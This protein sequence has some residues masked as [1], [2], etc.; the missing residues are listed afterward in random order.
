MD[1]NKDLLI[2]LDIGTD[3]IGWATTDENFDLVRIKGKTA[4]GSR[5]FKEA[6]DAKKRRLKRTNKRRL[7]RRNYRLKLLE[8]LFCQ[9]NL[10]IDKDPNFFNRMNESILKTE[11]KKYNPYLFASLDKEKEFYKHFPTIWHLR[12]DLINND[13]YALSDIRFVYLAI[14]HIIKYRGN[15]LKEGDYKID[16]LNDDVFYQVNEYIKNLICEL[17]DE[18]YDDVDYEVFNKASIASIKNILS[19]NEL[20]KITKKKEI[21]KLVPSIDNKTVLEHITMFASLICGSSYDISK[22]DKE[23]YEKKSIQFNSEFDSEEANLKMI[24]ADKYLLV[25]LAKQ[26][27][28]YFELKELLKDQ[29]NISSSFAQ[30]FETHKQCLKELKSLCRMVDEKYCLTGSKSVYFKI[31]KDK[32]S[33]K[34]YAAFVRVNSNAKTRNKDI[35]ILDTF[36]LETL[37][38]Y[39]EYLSSESQKYCL[40]KESC[41]LDEF[42]PIIAN[43]ST[44][45]IPHQLHKD[46]LIQ[47]LNNASRVY[48]KID[49]E[50]IDK[51]VKLFMFRVPYYYG[52]LSTK[53]PYS[54]V[55]RNN[56][57]I[58]TPWNI[59]EVIDDTKTKE[60]FMK[61]LTNSCQYL[62]GENVLPKKSIIYQQFIILDRLNAL[63]ING[64][65]ISQELKEDIYKNIILNNSKTTCKTISNYLKR[66]Y[67]VYKLDGVTFDGI[68]Q[69]DPFINESYVIFKSFFNKSVLS[70]EDISIAEDIIFKLN[71]FTDNVKDG[72]SVIKKE[73]KLSLE[74]EKIL[75]STSFSE[76]APFSYKLING[77]KVV[78]DSGVVLSI[79]DVMKEEVKNFQE[80]L[81]DKVY[82]FI[83]AIKEENEEF[84]KDQTK[85]EIVENIILSTPPK[86][87]RSTIQ[88]VRIIDE[89]ATLSKKE[90]KYISIEVTRKNDASLKGR[91][92]DSRYK[93]LKNFLYSLIKDKDAFMSKCAKECLEELESKYSSQ[94]L[95]E[96]RG[97]HLYLYFKQNGL[98]LYTGKRIDINDVIN[99]NKY[100]TDHIIPQSMIKD[101]S[102]DNLVLVNRIDNQ[103][104]KKA[105]YPI[106]SEIRNNE[107]VVGIWNYLHK[108]Q[109]IS[110][111][112]YTNL[113]R[114]NPITDDELEAFVNAQ[115]NVVNQSNITIKKILE[116]KYPNT[117]L[118]FSK[119]Q[120][121]S[122]IRDYLQIHKLRYLND[123]HHAVDAYL[124]I[125]SGVSLYKRF[126]S[127][128]Y[129]Y[130]KNNENRE[131][132][133]MEKYVISLINHNSLGEK[134]I[135]NC[136]ERHDFL[137]SYRIDY[138]EDSFYK[139][140]I[141]PHSDGK[142]FP[143]HTKGAMND[144]QRYGG[145]SALSTSYFYVAT[146]K[147]KKTYRT[148]VAVPYIEILLANNDK[149]KLKNRLIEKYIKHEKNETVDLDM[150]REIHSNQEIVYGGCSYL[151]QSCNEKEIKLKPI[152]PIFLP[153][154]FVTYLYKFDKYQKDIKDKQDELIKIY[155]DKEC[156]KYVEFS[157]EFNRLIFNFIISLSTNKKYDCCPM[158][159]QIRDELEVEKENAFLTKTIYEQIQYIISLIALFTRNSSALSKISNNKFRKTKTFI[160]EPNIYIVYKSVTGL[161]S[162]KKPL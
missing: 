1:N 79:L 69:K 116:I 18:E 33:E 127:K 85:D 24:L 134:I 138:S 30:I 135:K 22:L 5:I 126:S 68:N 26:V 92:T 44:S 21:L 66:H 74:Q 112:K 46:E 89:I 101:D 23:T 43:K 20:N 133:N 2:G 154:E 10:I 77:L 100:D 64:A 147:G 130:D 87:R 3:S 119:A 34:N 17:D 35:H 144:T 16:V 36:I 136:C 41:L 142:L 102:L 137:L 63:K 76:W 95:D 27:F 118:V 50:F 105:K 114:T 158:I 139:E 97:K 141:N 49:G 111:K 48:E 132:T 78:T 39:D 122:L 161:I 13:N 159:N 9:N 90:P 60:N 113:I 11:D 110:D 15:F 156:T 38:P 47:I 19:N 129:L 37:K 123:A 32:T 160:S 45:V 117:T 59:S 81:N 67:Q 157:K 143:V 55:V 104:I 150:R 128:F 80:V 153:K 152:S 120:Y 73:K 149:E 31:F 42:L 71:V 29:K 91:E 151:L 28:D 109:A 108:K 148:L 57:E 83:N 40:I 61:T 125:V 124:N 88:A 98:D 7:N 84:I 8:S 14:H 155:T 107:K 12:R 96:L 54:K 146:I 6:E 62:I 58:I 93:E 65:R 145:Y 56:N 82:H 94:K 115:I 75:L 121:P 53:S 106:P 4:W 25:D 131:S 52:P 86:M 140:T 72:V 103:N 162:D 99:S 51:I 70:N